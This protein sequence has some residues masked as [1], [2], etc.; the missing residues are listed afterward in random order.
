MVESMP[1]VPEPGDSGSEV[2]QQLGQPEQ[3]YSQEPNDIQHIVRTARSLEEYKRFF[4]ESLGQENELILDVGA[5]DATM[6]EELALLQDHQAAVVRLDAGYKLVPPK[7]GAEAVA[8]DATQMPFADETFDRVVSLW[9]LPHL[10]PEKGKDAVNEMMRVLKSGGQVM[11]FPGR[12]FK[13]V[14]G[15]HLEKKSNKR[16]VI[17]SF[18]TL[19]ITK[20]SDYGDW[21]AE[22]RET[23]NRE[24]IDYVTYGGKTF[25][26]LKW[27][28]RTGVNIFGTNQFPLRRKR[29]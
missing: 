8:A 24:I 4:G 26:F 2:Y 21:S 9:M 6:A 10:G 13:R 22:K 19:V 15:D 5:G 3:T 11:L 23:L 7:G 1:S 16:S 17:P 27:G 25:E 18:P 28:Y 14:G 29:N 12:P 20:P